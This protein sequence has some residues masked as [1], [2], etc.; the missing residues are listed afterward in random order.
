M[1]TSRDAW[2]ARSAAAARLR[3]NPVAT[4][5]TATLRADGTWQVT[6]TGW[7]LVAFGAP[8]AVTVGGVALTRVE[9]IGTSITGRLVS[10]P[11]GRD[12]GLDLGVARLA[13]PDLRVRLLPPRPLDLLGWLRRWFGGLR[14]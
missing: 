10:L 3:P 14:P 7:N 13:A 12:V 5:A 11:A 9:A 8:P 1:S 2:L 6:V 4:T